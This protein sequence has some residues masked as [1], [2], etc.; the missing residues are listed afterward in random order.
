MTAHYMENRSEDNIE[1]LSVDANGLIP[2][3]VF[4]G[5]H[6]CATGWI[7]NILMELCFHMGIQFYMAHTVDHFKSYGSLGNLVKEK[8][9]DLL[10]YTNADIDYVS[11]LNFHRAFHVVRDPRDILVSA[12][13]SHM[14]SHSTKNWAALE[15]HRKRLKSL[16]FEEGLFCEMEFSKE[17]FDA[18][19]RW[20]YEQE[21]VLEVRMEDL[22]AYP[23]D[24]FMRILRL[25]DLLDESDHGYLEPTTHALQFKMN[26]LNQKGRRYMPANLPMFPVPRIKRS[27]VTCAV[28][29]AI[30]EQKSFKRMSGGR[31]K[32]QENVKNHFRKGVPGDWRNQFNEAHVAKFRS[33][34]NPL[35]LKL[36]Y[37]TDSD[38]AVG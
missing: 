11:G 17:Q 4:F 3:R 1:T 2:T 10:A 28:L 26:R 14:H 8:G 18:M 25:L 15:A 24:I 6:K 23:L 38:W 31:K 9:I 36:G 21:K 22:T 27:T 16:S 13:F 33:E 34:F 19:Y 30:L 5:H 7:D 35:L 29:N 12:Y 20:D 32:G 37:E